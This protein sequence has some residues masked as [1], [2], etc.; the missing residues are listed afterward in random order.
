VKPLVDN[1]LISFAPSIILFQCFQA[2]LYSM[3]APQHL[4]PDRKAMLRRV[5]YLSQRQQKADATHS[6]TVRP[7]P[8]FTQTRA[9]ISITH[10]HTTHTRK[11]AR[12]L[13]FTLAF[14]LAPRPTPILPTHTPKHNLLVHNPPQSTSFHQTHAYT[15]RFS[16][17]PSLT[18][19]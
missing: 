9:P 15:P 5:S 6:P 16:G 14:P 19:Y 3:S 13:A 4:S 18:S 17:S 8:S 2:H 12:K 1:V 10:A 11:P 7:F